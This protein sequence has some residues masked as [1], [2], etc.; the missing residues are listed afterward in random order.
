MIFE[1]L[2]IPQLMQ[3]FAKYLQGSG[4]TSAEAHERGPF[5]FAK[6]LRNLLP[7]TTTSDAVDFIIDD[8]GVFEE[9]SEEFEEE[10]EESEVEEAV[11]IIS[12]L[13]HSDD[14][15][16]WL[17]PYWSRLIT[18]FRKPPQHSIVELYAAFVV[19]WEDGHVLPF[20]CVVPEE[21]I[22]PKGAINDQLL[23]HIADVFSSQFADLLTNCS[24]DDLYTLQSG[25]LSRDAIKRV[26]SLARD[27]V[28]NVEDSERPPLRRA[29]R[30]LRAVSLPLLPPDAL[31]KATKNLGGK[32]VYKSDWR[33]FPIGGEEDEK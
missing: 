22:Q 11:H 9:E 33:I 28:L 4:L 19:R 16:D 8:Y 7:A 25:A 32:P 15:C 27:G 17:I 23:V 24:A 6:W 3:F 2:L 5:E 18:S 29:L 14:N 10:S 20:V 21:L 26:L 31:R 1:D 12:H 30:F 13:A